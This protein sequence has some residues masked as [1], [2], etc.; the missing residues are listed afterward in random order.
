[1]G[2]YFLLQGIV[3]TQGSNL[4]L[5]HL[6]HWQVGSLPLVFYSPQHINLAPSWSGLFL[7]IL[8]ISWCNFKRDFFFYFPF[9]IVHSVKKCNWFLYVNL[10]SCYLTEF[11]Y[12]FNSFCVESLEFSIYSI[13]SSAY[14]DSFTPSLPKWILFFLFLVWL[15]YLGFSILCSIEVV[16][17]DILVLF[18]NCSS[19]SGATLVY[20]G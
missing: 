11:V 13:L 12:H 18:W 10:V 4:C 3:P 17:V 14:N 6:L 8:F 2:C 20:L 1:M 15:L 5:L 16:R 19:Y 7:S 9:L